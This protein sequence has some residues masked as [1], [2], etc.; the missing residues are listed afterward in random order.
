M[1]ASPVNKNPHVIKVAVLQ[2]KVNKEDALNLLKD[3]AH[4]VSY[5][6]KEYQFKVGSLVEFYPRDKRLLGMN[7][8]KGVKIMLRLRSPENEFQFLPRESIMG[9]ML[10]ELTHNLFG[11]HDNKFYSKLDELRGR[12]WTIEQQGLFDTFLGNGRR[13][14][15]KPVR[16]RDLIRRQRNQVIRSRGRKLGSLT[17]EQGRR[18]PKEMAAIAAERRANDKKWCGDDKRDH[19]EEPSSEDLQEVIICDDIDDANLKA[20]GAS[21]ANNGIEIIDL[22]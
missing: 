18:T 17:G 13:L 11:A 1:G 12:Q 4:S 8:N 20:D 6:M 19:S 16:D 22:T 15:G 10:H 2:K 5:L 14:G 3:I 7:V 9:T 21:A